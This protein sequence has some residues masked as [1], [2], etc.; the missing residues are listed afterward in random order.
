[1]PHPP[2]LE[3]CAAEGSPAATS[4][5]LVHQAVGDLLHSCFYD[6]TAD[7]LFADGVT[8]AEVTAPWGSAA[9]TAA[10]E[11]AAQMPVADEPRP[12]SLMVQGGTVGLKGQSHEA[13]R[14]IERLAQT[15]VSKQYR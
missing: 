11:M 13:W 2:P 4:L 14:P 10:A 7:D 9:A 6:L 15:K 12:T 8:A 1:M 3:A 5:P